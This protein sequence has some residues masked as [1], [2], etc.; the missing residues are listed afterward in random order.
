MKFNATD[1]RFN[2]ILNIK[3]PNET[4][5]TTKKPEY[6]NDRRADFDKNKF[7]IMK[8]AQ[9]AK[10]SQ[11]R[12]AKELLLNTGDAILIKSCDICTKCGFGEG[13][14]KNMM[15]KILTDIRDELRNNMLE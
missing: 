3:D 5:L 4:R 7:A 2:T 11:N 12:N 15:G 6:R 9:I 14:G 1:A 8:D 10:F 13:S